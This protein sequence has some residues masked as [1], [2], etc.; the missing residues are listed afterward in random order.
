MKKPRLKEQIDYK[1]INEYPQ[2]TYF[3]AGY[4]TDTNASWRVEKPVVDE[5]KCR[6][7]LIC[8]MYCPDGTI[9]KGE[10]CVEI[11]YDFCKGCGICQVECPFDAIRMEED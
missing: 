1:N 11:D 2:G 10:T 8:Y 5:D 7:C 4:L 3:E 6:N 9:T